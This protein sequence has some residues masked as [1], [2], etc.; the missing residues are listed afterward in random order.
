MDK[1][2]YLNYTYNNSSWLCQKC[3]YHN[4]FS[5]TTCRRC[6]E[7]N[8]VSDLPSYAPNNKI[9]IHSIVAKSKIKKCSICFDRNADTAIIHDDSAHSGFC[10]L[11]AIQIEETNSKCPKCRKPIDKI[12][13]LF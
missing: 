13:K 1:Q 9:K 2:D 10:L 12:V 4:I 8:I 11:C 5:K 7:N 6:S 3:S